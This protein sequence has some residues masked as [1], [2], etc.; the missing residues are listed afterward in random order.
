LLLILDRVDGSSGG[1]VDGGRD[2]GV[3]LGGDGDGLGGVSL[4]SQQLGLE[5]GQAQV[6]VL[7][8]SQEEGG[9]TGVIKGVLGGDD[10]HVGGVVGVSEETFIGTIGLSVVFLESQELVLVLEVGASQ[11]GSGLGLGGIEDSG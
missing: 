4:V 9:V 7:V 6:G 2:L 5:F 10:V 11:E 1:P 8:F 3:D